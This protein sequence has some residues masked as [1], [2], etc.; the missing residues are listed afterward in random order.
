MTT[1]SV[2]KYLSPGRKFFGPNARK[3][4]VQS[5]RPR[6]KAVIV[7]VNKEDIPRNAS[8][9]KRKFQKIPKSV[10]FIEDD[11]SSD[12]EYETPAKKLKSKVVV[13]P[14]S[15]K[16]DEVSTAE[17]N[18]GNIQITVSS[19]NSSDDEID[20][21][22][23]KK[24]EDDGELESE[25]VTEEKEKESEDE[26][27]YDDHAS[28]GSSSDSEAE[29]EDDEE[30]QQDSKQ[31]EAEAVSDLTSTPTKPEQRLSAGE[32]A[33]KLNEARIKRVKCVEEEMHWADELAKQERFFWQT[34]YTKAVTALE[35]ERDMKR[36]LEKQL[37]KVREGSAQKTRIEDLEKKLTSKEAELKETI[38][39]L[40]ETRSQLMSVASKFEQAEEEVKTHSKSLKEAERKLEITPFEKMCRV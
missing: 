35:E 11:F 33:K 24:M 2:D 22:I 1:S 15:S 38:D 3:L 18:S 4:P 30:S 23:E 7:P 25:E 8:T 34:R 32:I 29:H 37:E 10:E 12:E 6:N 21:I 16:P 27:D 26:S 19:G 40:Q 31:P 39:M 17:V 36:E 14:Q 13:V 5:K 28:S 9:A 20:R